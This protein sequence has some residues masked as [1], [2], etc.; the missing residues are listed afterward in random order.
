MDRLYL[1]GF[2][3]SNGAAEDLWCFVVGMFMLLR[4]YIYIILYTHINMYYSLPILHVIEWT[5]HYIHIHV[6]FK[7]N[8]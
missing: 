3:H 8:P 7:F 4:L 1:P 2:C 6:C 5:L